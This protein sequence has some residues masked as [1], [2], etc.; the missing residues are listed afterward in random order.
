M[1]NKILLAGGAV[2]IL[3]L[4]VGVAYSKLHTPNDSAVTA[5][6]DGVDTLDFTL[7]FYNAWL[8]AKT[9]TNTNVT[10]VLNDTTALTDD[11]KNKLKTKVNDS[12]DPVLCLDTVPPRIGA[13]VIFQSSTT[14]QYMVLGRKMATSTATKAIVSLTHTKDGWKINDISCSNGEMPPQ[15]EFSFERRGALL[16]SV[17][18]PL[19]PKYWH[20]IFEENGEQG[21]FA[22]LT[23]TASSSCTY[24][25]NTVAPCDESKFEETQEALVQGDATETGVN[26]RFMKLY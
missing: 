3:A 7:A 22:A 18:E 8:D 16:K 25:D 12:P 10:S 21:H 4:A 9:S 2:I 13:K 14:A 5:A 15:S 20:L 19:D 23:F 1:K 24:T 26:V 11:L 6:D 17:P